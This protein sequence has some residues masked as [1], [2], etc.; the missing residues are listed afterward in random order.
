[1]RVHP[2]NIPFKTAL[3]PIRNLVVATTCLLSSSVSLQKIDEIP[4]D[5]FARHEISVGRTK[6]TE[7]GDT[8]RYPSSLVKIANKWERASVVVDLS[9][10]KLYHYKPDGDLIKDYKIASGKPATPTH[11]AISKVLG[12]EYYPYKGAPKNSQR[13]LHPKDYGSRIILLGQVDPETG[14]ISGYNGEFIH[15]AKNEWSIG[16]YIS[17]GCMRMYNKDV[18]ELSSKIKNGQIVNIIK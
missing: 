6:I 16:K 1:M 3:K 12:V 17:G 5:E 10:N 11:T 18:K 4:A 15:G 7:A 2:I 9:C 13:A 8:I 14:A